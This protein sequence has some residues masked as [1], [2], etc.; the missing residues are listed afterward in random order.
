MAT[1]RMVPKKPAEAVLTEVPVS[2]ERREPP[3]SFEAMNYRELQATARAQNLAATGSK[4]DIIA[5]LRK[6]S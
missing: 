1:F 5:R 3:D 2:T 4:A 6:P